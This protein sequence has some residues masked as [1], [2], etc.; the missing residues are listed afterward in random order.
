MVWKGVR[1]IG[2]ATNNETRINVCRYRSGNTLSKNTA[3]MAGAY[4]EM[5]LPL[6]RSLEACIVEVEQHSSPT[7]A[8]PTSSA[9]AATSSATTKAPTSSATAVTSSATTPAPAATLGAVHVGDTIWLKA[10]TGKYLTV[11]GTKMHAKWNNRL[12]WEAF[13]IEKKSGDA[14]IM[15]GDSIYLRAHT[16]NRVT[17]QNTTVHAKWDHMDSWERLVI[18]KKEEVGGPIYPNDTVYLRA[19][20]GKRVAVEGT[21]VQAEWDHMGSWQA[22]VLESDNATTRLATATAT[23]APTTTRTPTECIA[24]GSLG[25]CEP[26]LNNAQCGTGRYCCPYMKK[27]VA[28]SRESCSSPIANCR[29]PCHSADPSQCACQNKD[30]PGKWQLPSC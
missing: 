16:G 24:A 27:C 23:P 5:V 15:S 19:H 26:C 7:T 22:L 11:Q 30:F 6:A 28:S 8:T 21:L 1:E 17:V 25:K 29:P 13:I 20:T 14:T 2:C 18:E 10:H 12:F 9:T 4:K 3:N